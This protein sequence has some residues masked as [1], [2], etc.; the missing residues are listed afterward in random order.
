MWFYVIVGII[1]S[2][3]IMTFIVV[4]LKH[5][6]LDSVQIV[7][8]TNDGIE[9]YCISLPYRQYKLKRVQAMC[10]QQGI[11]VKGF[12]GAVGKDINFERLPTTLLTPTY[13]K[14]LIATKNQRGH[15]GCTFS[16]V[17]ML[18]HISD[19][20]L[21]R[22][23]IFEDDVI[24]E[25]NFHSE[26]QDVLV[27]MDLVDPQWD[28]LLLGFSCSYDSY[29]KCHENDKEKIQLGRIVRVHRFMG[30]WGIVVNG[31]KAADNILNH[32]FPIGWHI[33]H[34]YTTLSQRGHIKIYGTI[35]S[36][37][38]H[39]GAIEISSWNYKASKNFKFYTSDTNS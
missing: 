25:G 5:F 21:N 34:W 6:F 31:Y 15:L 9:Y 12:T 14:H 4:F 16:H 11:H 36:L 39:P 3:V 38:F 24:I 27:K 30:L 23:V 7:E 19:N 29:D 33:D 13:K 20:K 1:I 32:L 22:T 18:Q 17:G 8:R 2:V 28:I 10:A 35:P 26:L 37:A